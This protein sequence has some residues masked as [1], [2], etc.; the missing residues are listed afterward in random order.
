M[1][2][3]YEVG[4][5][6]FHVRHRPL[7]KKE[8]LINRVECVPNAPIYKGI[9]GAVLKVEKNTFVVKTIDS[10]V[11]VLEW[12]GDLKIKVGDRLT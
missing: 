12:S 5:V 8:I 1:L 3:T 9:P 2:L 6:L 11:R 10:F 7:N 4:P